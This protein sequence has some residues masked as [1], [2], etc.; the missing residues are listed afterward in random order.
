MT[1]RRRRQVATD[2]SP[3]STATPDLSQ[4]IWEYRVAAVIAFQKKGVPIPAPQRGK[5]E[6]DG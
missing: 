1:A 3:T 5:E 2:N 6:N 4:L